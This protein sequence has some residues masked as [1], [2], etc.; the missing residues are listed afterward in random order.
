MATTMAPLN[1][2]NDVGDE[3]NPGWGIS[4][5]ENSMVVRAIYGII[6]VLGITGNFVVCLVL[7][8]VPSLRSHTSNFLVHLSLVDLILC[9][10][11][12]PFHL[13]PHVPDP[14]PGVGGD[15]KCR[16]YSSKFPLWTCALVSICSL[17]TVNLERYIAIVY[18]IKYKNIYTPRN[19]ALM[20]AACWAI[21][22]I[23]NS[24]TFY[25]YGNNE[26]GHCVFF[27]WPTKGFQVV[28]GLWN[29]I[30]YYL[31][32]FIFM[33]ITQWRVIKTL[34]DQAKMLKEKRERTVSTVRKS[35][36]RKMWQ[37][38]AAQELEKT[39]LIVSITYAICWAPNQFLF[40]VF[41]LSPDPE[42]VDFGAAYY[43]FTVIL[44]V[45]NSCL[46]PIIYTM[47]NRPFRRG[48]RKVFGCPR[49]IHPKKQKPVA[50]EVATVNSSDI[51]RLGHG[52][53]V[54]VLES[55]NETSQ[56]V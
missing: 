1:T 55:T 12:V 39:L 38:H 40:I 7:L 19:T 3:L 2:T 25:V 54:I 16:L 26:D 53:G 15:I 18:P 33:V 41:N 47:K 28:L 22:I 44:A 31:A 6:A 9:I 10:W 51:I 8:R 21:G 24:Y 36:Y 43:H 37:V 35:Q 45:A 30:S 27:G 46:N 56:Q 5:I 11:A 4:E 23:S 14:S 42:I 29:F 48:I 20:I 52:P 17:V 13:F 49:G 34:R 50:A 32:P